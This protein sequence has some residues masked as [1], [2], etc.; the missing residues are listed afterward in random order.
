[1]AT[2]GAL[3]LAVAA[4]VGGGQAMV[5]Q[6]AVPGGQVS[7]EVSGP[8]D[9]RVV[10]CLPGLGD[11]RGQWRAVVPHFVAAGYRVVLVDLRGMGDSA[12][13][14][15][16][17]RPEDTGAD[18]VALMEALDA[19]DV[20]VM[21]NSFAAAAAVWAAAQAPQRVGAL[22]LT[23]PFVRA[24]EA[25]LALRVLLE[26]LFTGPWGPA[27]WMAYY[28][29]LYVGVRPP[30][31]DAHLQALRG[32]LDTPGRMAVLRAMMRASKAPAAARAGQVTAPTLVVMGSKDPDFKDPA[33]EAA[34]VATMLRGEVWMVDGAGHYPQ[35]EQPAALVEKTL[36]FLEGHNHG[37][38]GGTVSTTRD[39]GGHGTGG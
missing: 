31:Q 4:A 18:V 6:L 24:V 12:P 32:N 21:G 7:Y 26:V 30:D 3:G 14:F 39:H 17:Y 28:K 2:L 22:V 23:G 16:S 8:E 33:A 36:Q 29:T 13:T 20:V 15:A 19:R 35:A 25:P 11:T 10:V 38:Q 27:A 5:R 34:L 1:M 37:H 9:G